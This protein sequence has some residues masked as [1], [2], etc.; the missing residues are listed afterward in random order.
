MATKYNV[1]V[2]YAAWIVA[3]TLACVVL[4]TATHLFRDLNMREDALR[5]RTETMARTLAA[6]VLPSV[7][8]AN[9]QGV[10]SAVAA[11]VQDEDVMHVRILNGKGNA[12][13]SLVP[14]QRALAEMLIISAPIGPVS[15]SVGLVFPA[16]WDPKLGIHVT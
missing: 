3:T 14:E 6:V 15:N 7:R 8:S 5:R 12:L 4:L 16:Q 13:Y 2:Q 1:K 9:Q 10:A 11:V